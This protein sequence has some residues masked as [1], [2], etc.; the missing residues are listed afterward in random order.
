MGISDEEVLRRLD[1]ARKE[2]KNYHSWHLDNEYIRKI[3]ENKKKIRF[4]LD[5]LVGKTIVEHRKVRNLDEYNPDF[6]SPNPEFFNLLFFQDNS[7]LL[8]E[9]VGMSDWTELRC[10]YFD[11][12]EVKYTDELF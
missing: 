4:T 3:I 11:G 1:E 7:F 6:T 9:S 8:T 12:K 10:Y 2:A 5:D